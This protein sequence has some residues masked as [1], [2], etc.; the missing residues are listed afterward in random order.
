MKKINDLFQALG[1]PIQRLI[2]LLTIG[3]GAKILGNFYVRG[4]GGKFGAQ[5]STNLMNSLSLMGA[6]VSKK[7]GYSQ[8]LPKTNVT[9]NYARPEDPVTARLARKDQS[10][11]NVEAH[12]KHFLA[13]VFVL[14]SQ[15]QECLGVLL[16][17]LLIL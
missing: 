14:G 8:K 10:P 7:E 2:G 4:T 11:N 15:M 6:G 5:G 9:N 3:M 13:K 16:L 12:Q 1:E 17:I